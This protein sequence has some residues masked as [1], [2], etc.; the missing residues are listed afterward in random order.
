MK[1]RLI[2]VF[3][4]VEWLVGDDHLYLKFSAKLTPFE[5]KRRFSIDI[6]S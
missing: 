1:E 4:D 3:R 2:L 6:C 5:Q